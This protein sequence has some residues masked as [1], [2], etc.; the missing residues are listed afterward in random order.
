[1]R[2]LEAAFFEGCPRIAKVSRPLVLDALRQAIIQVLPPLPSPGEGDPAE[3]QLAAHKRR[4]ANPVPE[5]AAW[6][7]ERERRAGEGRKGRAWL[8]AVLRAG[9]DPDVYLAPGF[10][11][12]SQATE[13]THA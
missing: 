2:E 10:G 3:R 1:M 9:P 5:V 7:E 12:D 6:I 8:E 13:A 4:N 11:R